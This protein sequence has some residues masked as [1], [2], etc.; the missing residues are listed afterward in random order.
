MTTRPLPGYMLRASSDRLP[1][2][3]FSPDMM[4]PPKP[5]GTREEHAAL[6]SEILA[7]RLLAM[8]DSVKGEA[9]DEGAAL[10]CRSI[11]VRERPSLGQVPGI[12][13]F[14]VEEA[15]ES[16]V[17]AVEGPLPTGMNV[18]GDPFGVEKVFLEQVVESP[19]V[20]SMATQFELLGATEAT[21]V[22]LTEIMAMVTTASVSGY[23]SWHPGAT[24]FGVWRLKRD[25]LDDYPW[26]NGI[27]MKDAAWCLAPVSE[28][29]PPTRGALRLSCSTHGAETW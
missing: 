11:P 3:V 24:Y 13:A 5:I 6:L 23:Y 22:S 28:E 27:P 1:I 9:A 12:D 25:H 10:A 17:D 20:L 21:S 2:P 7:E 18:V 8:P 26:R 14:V 29:E 15:E 16:L 19:R 4:T